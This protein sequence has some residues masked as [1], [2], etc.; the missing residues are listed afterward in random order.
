MHELVG[1]LW[2]NVYIRMGPIRTRRD[3]K[4]GPTK[5]LNGMEMVLGTK[6]MEIYTKYK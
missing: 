5:D 2:I 4:L 1:D 3:M 6:E